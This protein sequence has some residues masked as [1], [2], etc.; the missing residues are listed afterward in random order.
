M[1]APPDCHAVISSHRCPL[2]HGTEASVTSILPVQRASPCPTHLLLSKSI[3]GSRL[4]ASC[5]GLCLGLWT[6]AAAMMLI[7][8]KCVVDWPTGPSTVRAGWAVIQLLALAL[9]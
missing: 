6:T 5:Q 9:A 8:G 4:S 1:R 3:G 2:E 7:C